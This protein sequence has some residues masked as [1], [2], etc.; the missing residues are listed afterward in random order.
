M[1]LHRRLHLLSRISLLAAALMM[2]GC[3]SS[4]NAAQGPTMADDPATGAIASTSQAAQYEA[5]PDD[6]A[7]IT[8]YAN[9]L[10]DDG[11]TSEA[12]AVLAKAMMSHQNSR[13]IAA[14]YGKA[15]AEN[16]QFDMALTVI[17]NTQDPTNPDWRLINAEAAI[18]DQMGQ[19]ADARTLYLKALALAPDQPDILNNQAMSY[20]LGGDPATAEH[21]LRQA[22]GQPG[23]STRVRMNLAL[24]VAVQGKMDEADRIISEAQ[25][26]QTAAANTAWLRAMLSSGGVRRAAG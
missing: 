4:R 20:M 6:P 13:D 15:L 1:Y 21:I 11:R 17:R 26:P 2:S 5:R 12:V 10:R 22:V 23:A 14:L 9:A 7:A 3:M 18:L 24:A 16:G 19:T 8:A 25:S